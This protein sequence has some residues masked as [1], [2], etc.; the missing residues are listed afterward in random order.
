MRAQSLI[1]NRYVD[2]SQW[3]LRPYQISN[4]VYITKVSETRRTLPRTMKSKF[5]KEV[6]KIKV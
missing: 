1:L 5:H 2:S 4:L 6:N 3:N